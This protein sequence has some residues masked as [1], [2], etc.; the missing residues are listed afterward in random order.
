[1]RCWLLARAARR[2]LANCSRLLARCCC[3][4]ANHAL[5]NSRSA[6]GIAAQTAG[7]QLAYS[8]YFDYSNQ[9]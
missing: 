7:K 5:A 9:S 2:L 1:M 6:A 4:A 3:C 8:R